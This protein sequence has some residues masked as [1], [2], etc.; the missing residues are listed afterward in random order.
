[1]SLLQ[2]GEDPQLPQQTGQMLFGSPTL[3]QLCVAALL[4]P[5]PLAR[6]S[7]PQV[8]GRRGTAGGNPHSLVPWAHC[9]ESK[10]LVSF[11]VLAEHRHHPLPAQGSLNRG[12]A[13]PFRAGGEGTGCNCRAHNGRKQTT[14]ICVAKKTL[15][16]LFWPFSGLVKCEGF[17]CRS[18]SPTHLCTSLHIALVTQQ[19]EYAPYPSQRHSIT[20]NSS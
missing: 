18:E 7:S 3:P 1:M 13:G 2:G 20:P 4:H 11:S 17:P 16:W 6:E 9:K 14:L 12:K 15:V 10:K 5:R 19:A 8:A